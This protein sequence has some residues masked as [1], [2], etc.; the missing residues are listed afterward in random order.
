[1]KLYL[2]EDATAFRDFSLTQMTSNR[3]AGASERK[4]GDFS[5][6]WQKHSSES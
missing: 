3:K 5:I 4:N 6:N 1:M 2:M